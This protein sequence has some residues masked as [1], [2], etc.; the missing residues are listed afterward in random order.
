[1]QS[2]H[3]LAKINEFNSRSRRKSWNKSRSWRGWKTSPQS[4]HRECQL[5][6]Q[7]HLQRSVE[8]NTLKHHQ[9]FEVEGWS[10]YSS[11]SIGRRDIHSR[12][13]FQSSKRS[14]SCF[15][16]HSRRWR[17]NLR[18]N[19]PFIK[20]LMIWWCVILLLHHEDDTEESGYF[21]HDKLQFGFKKFRLQYQF[22]TINQADWWGMFLPALK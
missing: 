2:R 6:L 19:H 14:S 9:H 15:A 22:I 12:A 18:G 17:N 3:L 8:L 21:W 10:F 20:A 7:F 4:F 11:G 1:M 5:F 16:R 13:R